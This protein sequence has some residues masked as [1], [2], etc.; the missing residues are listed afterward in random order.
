MGYTGFLLAKWNRTGMEI[1]KITLLMAMLTVTGCATHTGAQFSQ[2]D[3]TAKSN[4]GTVIFYRP[5]Q[6]S[7]VGFGGTIGRWTIAANDKKITALGDGTFTKVE[8]PPGSYKFNGQTSI[9]DTVEK[10]EIKPG[11]VHYVKAFKRG[12]S[13]WTFLILKEVNEQ[14]ARQDLQKLVLQINDEKWAN[15]SIANPAN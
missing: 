7:F 9:I 6:F 11:A 1:L 2:Q 14:T 13:F 8:L 15:N 12:F 4:L 5:H 10:I 3:I